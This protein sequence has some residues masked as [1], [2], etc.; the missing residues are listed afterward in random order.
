MRADE[1]PFAGLH[2]SRSA[3]G[4]TRGR[5]RNRVAARE[6]LERAENVEP[7]SRRMETRRAARQHG[8]D[9]NA[10]PIGYTMKTRALLS[11]NR[12][13]MAPREPMLQARMLLAL[14]GKPTA[15][16]RFQPS[17]PIVEML[18]ERR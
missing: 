3:D 2:V 9:E 13:W 17:T 14:A 15:Q 16:D 11:E 4:A 12:E 1:D 6:H 5:L 8:L 18:L 10:Q 7:A